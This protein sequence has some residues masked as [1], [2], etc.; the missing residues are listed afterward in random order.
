M[1][2][3]EIAPPT[4]VPPLR[5]K[6]LPPSDLRAV[7]G[8]AGADGLGATAE[9]GARIGRTTRGQ[10]K[11]AAA[12]H[13]GV[14]CDAA[15]GNDLNAAALDRDLDAD[16][17]ERHLLD[18]ALED[19]CPAVRSAGPDDERASA[20]DDRV[21]IGAAGKD[22]ERVA[23]ADDETAV[24]ATAEPQDGASRDRDAGRQRDAAEELEGGAG[25]N[26]HAAHGG[27]GVDRQHAAAADRCAG[28]S[29]PLVISSVP[30][31][32]VQWAVLALVTVQVP[33]TTLKL[34]KP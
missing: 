11:R 34:V 23:A 25:L 13:V 2:P 28:H 3:L 8:A 19:R 12:R 17:A 31:L 4:A 33:P 14:A 20:A 15:G 30:A 27:A 21:Q 6:S 29:P 5:T 24:D 22:F 7:V 32:M 9:D 1:P 26:G 18:A 10:D 16:A